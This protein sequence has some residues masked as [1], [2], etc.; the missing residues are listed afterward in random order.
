MARPRNRQQEIRPLAVRLLAEDDGKPRVRGYDPI[1]GAAT[2]I[3]PATRL[4]SPKP[5]A[6]VRIEGETPK[7]TVVPMSWV[8][9]GVA[10]GWLRLEGERVQHRPGGPA[11]EPWRVTHTFLQADAIILACVGGDVRYRVIRQPDKYDGGP[12]IGTGEPTDVHAD[13]ETSVEWSYT[14]ELEDG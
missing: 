4:P 9:R 1:T 13:P 12:E 3:D 11:E 6:G 8:Q 7:R 14:L 10:E 2:L 5:L